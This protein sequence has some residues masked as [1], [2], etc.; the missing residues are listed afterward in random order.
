MRAYI[1]ESLA[2]SS[3]P[4]F[5][6]PALLGREPAGNDPE[7]SGLHSDSKKEGK[8]EGAVIQRM[9]QLT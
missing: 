4:S 1:S 2:K 9:S 8:E 3:D 7:P 5:H 6:Q